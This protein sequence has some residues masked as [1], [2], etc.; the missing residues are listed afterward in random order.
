MMLTMIRLWSALS[1][2]TAA[3]IAVRMVYAMCV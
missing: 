3:A 2:A 1:L